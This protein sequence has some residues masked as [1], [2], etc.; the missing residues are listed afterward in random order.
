MENIRIVSEGSHTRYS[1][2]IR[3]L[4]GREAV[5]SVWNLNKRERL[6]RSP[7]FAFQSIANLG[8]KGG[9][10]AVS[11]V[12]IRHAV[13]LCQSM[14]FERQR[15]SENGRLALPIH[16]SIGQKEFFS[17]SSIMRVSLSGHQR[18]STRP[19]YET[20]ASSDDGCTLCTRYM[21]TQL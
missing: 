16:I 17:T 8:K 12:R 14:G 7:R 2:Y 9:F 21:Y 1:T 3:I 11:A 18:M 20:S 15:L 6:L 5:Q 19:C 4:Y 13:L 10:R